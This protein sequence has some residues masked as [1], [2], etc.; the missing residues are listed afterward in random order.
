MNTT[1]TRTATNRSA[2]MREVSL[3]AGTLLF[4]STLTGAAAAAAPA[5][6]NVFP[7]DTVKGCYVNGSGT[8]CRTNAPN[9]PS[10]CT[11]NTHVPMSWPDG[12]GDDYARYL[13]ADGV[14]HSINGFAVTG[15]SNAG[16]IP[17]TGPGNRLMWYPRKA[18]LRA[19]AVSGALWDDQYIGWYSTA[20]GLDAVASGVRSLSI[21]TS[22]QA[23]GVASIALGFQAVASGQGAKAIGSNVTASEMAAMALGYGTVASGRFSTAIGSYAS[24]NGKAGAFVYGDRSTETLARAVADNQFV[25]RAARF[26]LGANTNV[27]ATAGR[28]IE[29]STGAY[30]STGGTW[31]NSSDVARKQNF[32]GVD[33][34]M[35]LEKVA[36]LPIQTWNYKDDDVA[37]RHMGPTAQDFRAA[38]HLGDTDKAIATVD[39]DGV[40]LAAIQALENARES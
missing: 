9:A 26:W 34:E 11:R 24:T 32:E 39:A 23:S 25:V 29:T 12:K 7:S 10:G 5:G 1:T 30:L 13:L 8:I 22:S 17:V 2:I 15:T 33:G 14:R 6:A 27:T 38:F 4:V 31:T 28:F 19:A 3:T 20:F 37:V 21:G 16:T 36:A 40:S 35:V 18:A